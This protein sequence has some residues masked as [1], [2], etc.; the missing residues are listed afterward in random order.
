MRHQL[1]NDGEHALE[2]LDDAFENFE[3][4]QAALSDSIRKVLDGPLG[5]PATA[6][7]FFLSLAVWMAFDQTQSDGLRSIT[8]EE[9]NSTELLVALD[10]KIRADETGEIIETD[11]VISMEQPS[12]V[13]FVREHIST[14][15]DTQ[16]E[17]V[18]PEE[19]K[20]IYSMLLIE[21]LALSYAVQAPPDQFLQETEVLA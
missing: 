5:E 21:M 2:R 15:L 19:L 8:S 1:L 16:T 18:D 7:G 11:E 20:E 9:L 10:E 3:V 14:T 6:L 13:E 12:L 17:Y 4:S